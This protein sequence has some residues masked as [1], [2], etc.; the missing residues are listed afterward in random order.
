M[1]NGQKFNKNKEK[2]VKQSLVRNVAA[3]SMNGKQINKNLVSI[4]GKDCV[5]P[6]NNRRNTNENDLTRN[7]RESPHDLQHGLH[8]II[9]KKE[10][11]RNM[12]T[13]QLA[14]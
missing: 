8:G 5:K 9:D 13:H 7:V 12:Q 1:S 4:V 11:N 10:I 14:K 2:I 6:T 3:G